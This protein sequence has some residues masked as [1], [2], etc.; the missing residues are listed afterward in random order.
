MKQLISM[1]KKACRSKRALLPMFSVMAMP[2]SAHVK[3]FAPYD[4]VTA[5]KGIEMVLTPIFCTIGVLSV[6]VVFV[7]A[8]LDKTLVSVNSRLSS[9]RYRLTNQVDPE[10]PFMVIRYGLLIFFVSIWTIGGIVLTPE[11]KHH[12]VW[13]SALQL[14][15]IFSLL[16]NRTTWVAGVGMFV[17]WLYAAFHYGFF[18]LTDY[19]IFLGIGFFI[20][21]HSAK[22]DYLNKAQSFNILYAA[23]AFTLLWASI[24][25]FVYSQ[26]TFPILEKLPHITMGFSKEAFMVL[27]GFVEF[28]LAFLLVSM[29]GIGFVGG[30]TTLLSMFIAAIWD[31]GKIDA[32]GHLMIVVA[33]FIMIAH[34]PSRLNYRLANLHSQPVMNAFFI[35]LIYSV[36]LV[37]FFVIYYSI[38]KLWLVTAMH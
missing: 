26:W 6:L 29:T 27:A 2:A 18:H 8:L 19:A 23:I 22:V 31:F 36:S 7:L 17:L 35:T 20:I 30:A 4:I 34:G 10:Y 9:Y 24:E 3:W 37:F 21:Y 12:S 15:M 33:L 28:V 1:M 11:L 14:V 16:F 5:P 32:I 38:H 13:I 25:K